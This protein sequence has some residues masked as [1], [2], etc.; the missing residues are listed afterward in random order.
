MRKP[1]NDFNSYMVAKALAYCVFCFVFLT[2]CCVIAYKTKRVE[3]IRSAHGQA[4]QNQMQVFCITNRAH[5]DRNANHS[6]NTSS[7]IEDDLPPSYSALFDNVNS[8]VAVIVSTHAS[9][10]PRRQTDG[11]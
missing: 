9:S 3:E 4:E 2:I 6:E 10:N 5:L 8:N 1:G 11:Q 7:K